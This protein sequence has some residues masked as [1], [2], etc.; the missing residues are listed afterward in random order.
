MSNLNPD[1]DLKKLEAQLKEWKAGLHELEAEVQKVDGDTRFRCSEKIY[2][3]HQK[4]EEMQQTL[5]RVWKTGQN[6]QPDFKEDLNLAWT[7]LKEN[8]AKAKSEFKRGY[9]EGR[10][11]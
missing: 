10:E 1:D 9:R 6:D 4:T 8:V 2:A 5:A 11:K 3:L 7:S